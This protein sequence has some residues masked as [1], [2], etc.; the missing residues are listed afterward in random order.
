MR[1]SLILYSLW[2][3]ISLYWPVHDFSS[4]FTDCFFDSVFFFLS[5]KSGSS[6]LVC[7]NAN[8]MS[9][10]HNYVVSSIQRKRS[11]KSILM[12]D[13]L[14]MFFTLRCSLGTI[15]LQFRRNYEIAFLVKCAHLSFWRMCAPS[16]NLIYL[17]ALRRLSWCTR[18]LFVL[19][20]RRFD[21]KCHHQLYERSKGWKKIARGKK[22][23]YKLFYSFFFPRINFSSPLNTTD[24]GVL[25]WNAL[26]LKL[27][28]M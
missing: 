7:S 25:R 13:V 4:S 18:E 6:H 14:E 1:I 16:I 8:W 10:L 11:S 24:D 15:Q 19:V 23:C 9:S 2:H 28:Y 5:E 3:T 20:T 27:I 17:H 12:P 21:V 22:N 26:R